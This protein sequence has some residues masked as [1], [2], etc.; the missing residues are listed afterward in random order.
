MRADT[1]PNRGSGPRVHAIARADEG[2]GLD[3][4]PSGGVFIVV[5]NLIDELRRDSAD[6]LILSLRM[7]MENGSGF[8]RTEADFRAWRADAGFEQVELCHASKRR[9]RPSL[10]SSSTAAGS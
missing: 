1:I 7:L 2:R 4:L 8:D 10:A 6:G 5:E 9:P 3:A